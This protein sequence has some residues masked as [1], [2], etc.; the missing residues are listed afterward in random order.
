MLRNA[1]VIFSAFMPLLLSAQQDTRVRQSDTTTNRE[2]KITYEYQPKFMNAQKIESVPVIDKPQVKPTL[3]TY[4]IKS[5]Q[6]NT[7]KIVKPMPV[8]DLSTA[9]ENIYP[10]SFIKIGYGNLRTPLAEVYLNNKQNTRYSYGAHYRFLQSNSDLNNTFA[11]FSRHNFK[12][13]ASNYTEIGEL[14]IE[15]NFRQEN[16][17]FY[18]YNTTDTVRKTEFSPDKS[19]LARTMRNFDARAYFNSTAIGNKKLKHRSQFNFYNF[20]IGKATENQYALS[21]KLYAGVPNF[22]DLKNG[23]ISAVIGIDYNIF[24]NDTLKPLKRFFVQFDPRFD[25]EY[26][27]LQ[28][29]AGFNTTLFLNGDTSNVY[30]NPVIKANYPLVEGVANLY[31]GIDG[32]YQKQS[33]RN[34]VSTNPYTSRYDISNLYE[35]V[36]TYLGLNAKMGSS[37]DAVFE[38]GYAD[39]S[40]MPLYVTTYKSNDS[41]SDRL[42]AF[43]VKYKQV[44]M[45]KF[46]A[47]FNYSF[48]EK[49]RIGL[50]GNFYNY[51]V[52]E[53]PYPWQLPNVDG[54]LN[55]RFN[56]A[57]KLYPHIDIIAMG[58]QK[59]RSGSGAQYETNSIDAFYDISAGVDYRFKN[60]L[61]A[62]V[63]ANNLMGARYQRW[64]N[65]QVY[66]FNIIGGITMIF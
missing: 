61:S 8:A 32:R 16:Y 1:I 9:T 47:A 31:A 34:L 29:S 65:Y 17:N 20:S 15:V 10:S 38:I 42:N 33:L 19:S 56:I 21:S 59:Q 41:T 28:I 4:Q 13:Y 66:G 44:S 27:G 62:F 24:T 52:T 64:Y 36:R 50:I 12:G 46:M 30:V 26:D 63:Q 7:E 37:A 45:L 18:G 43:S 49:I 51:E 40:N 48:S 25:F 57:N 14:G 53:E 3:F 2:V 55:M 5:H 60:K 23:Q 39:I 54:K 35:N 58:G 6:V 11:D 22:N